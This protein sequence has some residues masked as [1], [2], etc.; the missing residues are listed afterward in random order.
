MSEC[1]SEAPF[2]PVSLW[3]S[4]ELI[5]LLSSVSRGGFCTLLSNSINILWME[6]QIIGSECNGYRIR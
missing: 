1:R 4:L 3:L 5:S 6:S 2:L